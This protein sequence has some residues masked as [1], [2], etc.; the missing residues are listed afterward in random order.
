M[1]TVLQGAEGRLTDA[2]R[3]A[4]ASRVLLILEVAVLLGLLM[5]YVWFL[6]DRVPALPAGL[7]AIIVASWIW[8][9]DSPRSLGLQPDDFSR[10]PSLGGMVVLALGVIILAAAL[11]H[12]TFDLDWGRPGAAARRVMQYFGWALLQQLILHGYFTNRLQQALRGKGAA[13]V[14]AGVVF[15]I[16]HLP[17]PTLTVATLLGGAIGARW[18]LA[19]RNVYP[20]ALAH[21]IL[22]VATR[23]LF[24]VSMKVGPGY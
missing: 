2:P 8:R 22:A 24:D 5:V 21:A 6:Q 10:V 19:S 4:G 15:G 13:S 1:A 11:E 18:F 3:L 12:Q 23:Q 16:V 14:A 9:K 7:L 17:N 20:L